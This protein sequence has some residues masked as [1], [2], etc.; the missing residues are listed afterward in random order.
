MRKRALF[1]VLTLSVSLGLLLTSAGIVQGPAS[2]S[3][4]PWRRSSDA[5]GLGQ[6]TA[7]RGGPDERGL[8]R[9][10][11]MQ[12]PAQIATAPVDVKLVGQMGGPAYAVAVQGNHA[13]VAAAEAGVRVIDVSDPATPIERGTYDTPGFAQDIYLA[14]GYIFVAAREA[15]LRVFDISDPTEPVEVGVYDA[16]CCAFRV[17]VAGDTTASC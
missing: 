17:H 13:F 9:P 12:Q 5:N 2:V 7:R 15:G 8:A 10:G 1:T 11:A 6:R 3:A 14:G 16:T 4:L